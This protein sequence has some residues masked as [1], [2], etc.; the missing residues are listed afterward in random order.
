MDWHGM[1]SLV[2]GAGR[3]GLA[4][5]K[6]LQALGADVY[7]TDKKDE[8]ALPEIVGLKIPKDHLL[9]GRMI[10]LAE[11]QPELVVLSPGVPT[12]LP[13]IQEAM[14]KGIK[15]W[16]EVERALQNCPAFLVGVTGTNGKTTTTALSGELIRRTGRPTVV[17]GNIGIPLSGHVENLPPEGVVVAE[18]SS[19]QLELCDRLRINVAIILNITPDHLD[20]HKTLENYIEAKAQILKNQRPEDVAILNWDDP[21]VRNLA[22]RTQ[23]RVVYFSSTGFI[24]EGVSLQ[25]GQ[26]VWAEKGQVTPV[27]EPSK[28]H[29]RGAHNLENVM[30]AIVAVRETGLSWEEIRQGL[31][32]FQGVSH[33]QEVVGR[34]DNILF[35]NDSKGT[36]PD[37]AVKALEAFDEPIVLIAGGK[38]K[39]LSFDGFMKVVKQKVRSLILLGMAADLMEEAARKAGVERIIRANGF[40]EGVELAIREARAGDVVLLSP[41]CTSWDMFNSYE[42]RGEL[43]KELV[44]THYK[45]PK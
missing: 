26:I 32:E 45:E 3:S 1:R 30:A 17:A 28:L 35:I 16:G 41:A 34:F 23:G 38:N 13:F 6:R 8:A 15:V 22:S 33:R 37:A 10:E 27:I 39:G 18:L 19:F 20:R 31:R 42:E 14:E 11:V 44:R 40:P 4:A 29:L 12:N 9:L 36:N 5:V 24:P 7:L 43:F 2:V 21:A 25:D